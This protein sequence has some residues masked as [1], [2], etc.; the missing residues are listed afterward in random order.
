[1]PENPISALPEVFVSNSSISKTV[2]DALER[3]EVRKLGSRLYTRNLE[4]EPETLISR[5]WYFLIPAYSPDA[6]IADR[7]ALENNPAADG[8]V[9]LISTKTRDVELPGLLF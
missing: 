5:N 1:M 6:I 8:S 3:G 2:F 7:T 9:F 4:A